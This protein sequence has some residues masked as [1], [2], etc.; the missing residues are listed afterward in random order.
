MDVDP[1]PNRTPAR[2]SKLKAGD[3]RVSALGGDERK[4]E[5]GTTT[6]S[7]PKRKRARERQ[8]ADREQDAAAGNLPSCTIL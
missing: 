1:D 8:E 7:H 3:A 5:E 4:D 2:R 6:T